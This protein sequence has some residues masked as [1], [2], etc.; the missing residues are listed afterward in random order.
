MRLVFF[1]LFERSVT[2][3][4]L[5]EDMLL[6]RRINSTHHYYDDLYLPSRPC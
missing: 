2:C 4:E 1:G 6:D 3:E 5:L